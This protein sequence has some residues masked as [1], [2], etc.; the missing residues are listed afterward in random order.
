MT[1]LMHEKGRE[2][3]QLERSIAMYLPDDITS[4]ERERK[5]PLKKI[6]VEDER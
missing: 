3:V 4:R 1:S 2:S 5:M 6:C